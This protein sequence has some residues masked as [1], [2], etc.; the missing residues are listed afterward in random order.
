MHTTNS[1][2]PVK[3]PLV[4]RKTLGSLSGKARFAQEFPEH[5]HELLRVWVL[6]VAV[7]VNKSIAATKA[8]K[9]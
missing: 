6:V 1:P 4:K 8:L 3:A 5:D 9:W 7:P 2:A